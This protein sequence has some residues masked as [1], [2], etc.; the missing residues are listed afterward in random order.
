[1]TINKETPG[2]RWQISTKK[3]CAN[4]VGTL[5]PNPASISIGC[6]ATQAP[7]NRQEYECVEGQK[8]YRAKNRDSGRPSWQYFV[9]ILCGP[10]CAAFNADRDED[11]PADECKPQD[12]E[13]RN[14]NAVAVVDRAQPQEEKETGGA[15][16]DWAPCKCS[17]LKHCTVSYWCGCWWALDSILVCFGKWVPRVRLLSN[18]IS[19]RE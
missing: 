13:D 10:D 3:H 1:M 9:A 8:R 15:E 2:K 7:G 4:P 12:E 18:M 14:E 5:A 19:S 6:N 17:P 11:T 16:S